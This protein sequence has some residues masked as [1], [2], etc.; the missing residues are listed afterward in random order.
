MEWLV[1]SAELTLPIFDAL[2]ADASEAWQSDIKRLQAHI[3]EEAASLLPVAHA[4]KCESRPMTHLDADAPFV[5]PPGTP[6]HLVA[7]LQHL[8]G[9]GP[10]SVLEKAAKLITPSKPTGMWSSLDLEADPIRSTFA[11][12][13][14]DL[15][16]VFEPITREMSELLGDLLSR[17]P[18]GLEWVRV[19]GRLMHPSADTHLVQSLL[20]IFAGLLEMHIAEMTPFGELEHVTD[21][22]LHMM[23]AVAYTWGIGGGVSP[24]YRE[25][26]HSFASDLLKDCGLPVRG[27]IYDA[28]FTWDP[29]FGPA[30]DTIS[31]TSIAKQIAPSKVVGTGTRPSLGGSMSSGNIFVPTVDTERVSNLIYLAVQGHLPLMLVGP[32]GAGKSLIIR[33]T[34]GRLVT[35]GTVQRSGRRGGAG[36]GAGAGVRPG[37]GAGAGNAQP[38][39]GEG[40]KAPGAPVTDNGPKDVGTVDFSDMNSGTSVHVR[41]AKSF[42]SCSL[43]CSSQT[44][45]ATVDKSVM[46]LLKRKP[47]KHRGVFGAP[48]GSRIVLFVDD[49]NM[50]M[51][52][53]FGTQPPQEL[54]RLLLDRGTVISRALEWKRI[55]DLVVVAAIQKGTGGGVNPR[56]QRHFLSATVPLPDMTSLEFIYTYVYGAFLTREMGV[57]FKDANCVMVVR[58]TLEL[59][60]DIRAQ[61]L[62]TPSRSHYIYSTRDLTRMFQGMMM[63]DPATINRK[64]LTMLWVHEC[65]RVLADRLVSDAERAIFHDSLYSKLRQRFA[66][67]ESRETF[68][69]MGPVLFTAFTKDELLTM[70]GD[71]SAGEGES[72]WEDP[73]SRSG[74]PVETGTRKE[75]DVSGLGDRSYR[76]MED[77]IESLGWTFRRIVEHHN[78]MHPASQLQMVF[79]RAT[80]EHVTRIMRTLLSPNGHML[81]LGL[82]GTGKQTLARFAAFAAGFEV[83]KCDVTRSFSLNEFKEYV[84]KVYRL[85]GLN[86]K[87]TVFLLPDSKVLTTN[88]FVEMIQNLLT[89]RDILALFSPEDLEAIQIE[90]RSWASEN[91]YDMNRTSIFQ[92]FSD[93][94]SRNLRVVVTRSPVGNL[95][96]THIRRFPSLIHCCTVDWFTAWSEDALQLVAR[97]YLGSL[98]LTDPNF[99]T[100]QIPTL[101]LVGQLEEL[102]EQ[103]AVTKTEANGGRGSNKGDS[104][105]KATTAS[106]TVRETANGSAAASV[107]AGDSS[108]PTIPVTGK[109]PLLLGKSARMKAREEIA[110]KAAEKDRKAE[111]TVIPASSSSKQK[112]DEL[113]AT[114]PVDL[115]A[116]AKGISGGIQHALQLDMDTLVNQG[117]A[118]LGLSTSRESQTC[119]SLVRTLVYVHQTM[120]RSTASVY[121]QTKRNVYVTPKAFLDLIYTFL[122]VLEDRRK[123]MKSRTERLQGGLDLLRDTER[124]V[125]D[126]R[127]E[128]TE[129]MPQLQA[130]LQESSELVKVVESEKEEGLAIQREVEREEGRVRDLQREATQLRDE[131]QAELDETMPALEAANEALLALNNNDITEIKSFVSPPDLV[132]LTMEA[133]SLL[134]EVPTSNWNSA[135]LLMSDG[136]AFIRRLVE[137]EKDYVSDRT[138]K[139]LRKYTSHPQFTPKEV[140]RHS[141]AAMSMCLWVRAVEHYADILRVVKPKREHL[142]AMTSNLREVER[143]LAEKQV[144]LAEATAQLALRQERLDETL[145]DSDHLQRH[146]ERTELRLSR[147]QILTASLGEEGSRWAAEMATSRANMQHVLGDAVLTAGFL[148]YLGILNHKYREEALADWRAELSRN[149]LTISKDWSLADQLTTPVVRRAW[150][151]DL[152]PFGQDAL[153][154]AIIIQSSTRWPLIIDPQGQAGRWIRKSEMAFGLHTMQMSDPQGFSALRKYL[155]RGIPV[156]MEGCSSSEVALDPKFDALLSQRVHRSPSRLSVRLGDVDVQLHPHARIY[157]T[158]PVADPNFA[159]EVGIRMAIV[160][161]SVSMQGLQEQLLGLVVRN[162]DSELE[163][164][165][166]H[167]V[168]SIAADAQQLRELEDRVLNLLQSAREGPAVITDPSQVLLQ[169]TKTPRASPSPGSRPSK[170]P[171]SRPSDLGSILDREDL[172]STLGDSKV[173][174]KTLEKR[175]VEAEETEASIDR[176]RNHYRPVATRGA[177]LYFAVFDLRWIDPMY[178]YSLDYMEQLVVEA[179][180]TRDPSRD[181]STDLTHPLEHLTHLVCRKVSSG[182]FSR[183]QSL[184]LMLVSTTVMRQAGIIPPVVWDIFCQGNAYGEGEVG[185]PGHPFQRSATLPLS[186]TSAPPEVT[187]T[188]GGSVSGSDSTSNSIRSSS[189]TP[190]PH[191]AAEP[192]VT[193]DLPAETWAVLLR[194]ERAIP[195]LAGLSDSLRKD[196]AS[197]IAWW[198]TED[199]LESDTLLPPTLPYGL[200]LRRPITPVAEAAAERAS[201]ASLTQ[202]GGSLMNSPTIQMKTVPEADSTFLLLCILRLV[203]PAALPA[204]QRHY[205]TN[206]L[207]ANVFDTDEATM[208][209]VLLDSKAN[210]PIVLL[211]AKGAD[212]T[213]TLLRIA[214]IDGRK[215]TS[216]LR[217]L[218]MGQGQG[219]IAETVIAEA[220]RSGEWVLLAN[221]HVAQSWMPRLEREVER[222][223]RSEVLPTNQV[224][225]KWVGQK[226]TRRALR[227]K[228][229]TVGLDANIAKTLSKHAEIASNRSKELLKSDPDDR[230]ALHP[231]FRLWLT[232][233][234][235]PDFAGVVL[236]ASLKLT[237]EPPLQTRDIAV[238]AF[239]Q[240]DASFIDEAF[241]TRDLSREL[242]VSHSN[243]SLGSVASASASDSKSNKEH[244]NNENMIRICWRRLVYTTVTLHALLTQRSRFGSL[245]WNHPAVF[246]G[247]DLDVSLTT[248]HGFLSDALSKLNN[249]ELMS[250]TGAGTDS[251]SA[252]VQGLGLAGLMSSVQRPKEAEAGASD[253]SESL[254]SVT[255]KSTTLRDLALPWLGMQYLVG[256]INYGGRITDEQDR[257]ILKELVTTLI[258]PEALLPNFSAANGTSHA[259]D[260]RA[261]PGSPTLKDMIRFGQRRLPTILA[262]ETLCLSSNADLWL[263]QA[264][265]R[266]TIEAL[267]LVHAMGSTNLYPQESSSSTSPSTRMTS[268]TAAT[269]SPSATSATARVSSALVLDQAEMTRNDDARVLALVSQILRAIPA[270]LDI[271]AAKRQSELVSSLPMD[272]KD[273]ALEG[274]SLLDKRVWSKAV[275]KFRSS[276]F[277]Q[278]R[279]VREAMNSVRTITSVTGRMV[280][281]PGP[282]EN[283]TESMS[284]AATTTVTP[285]TLPTASEKAINSTSKALGVALLQEVTQ[286]NRLLRTLRTSLEH[287]EQATKGLAMNRTENEDTMEAL[288]KFKVPVAWLRASFPSQKPLGSWLTNLKQRVAFV[289][290]WCSTGAPHSF[291][292]SA[293]MMPQGLLNAVVQ[294]YARTVHVSIDQLRLELTP[295]TCAWDHHY[296][297]RAFRDIQTP[298]VPGKPENLVPGAP[299]WED[300]DPVVRQARANQG[301]IF[302]HGVYLEGA[303]WRT[304]TG[305]LE[306]TP[307]GSL[308]AEL[309]VLVARVV[310]IAE[311]VRTSETR[312]ATPETL[313]ERTR[314]VAVDL[315]DTSQGAGAGASPETKKRVTTKARSGSVFGEV[316]PKS[317][318]KG[319]GETLRCQLYEM[320]GRVDGQKDSQHPIAEISVPVTVGETR[321]WILRGV[322]AVCSVEAIP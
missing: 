268:T 38:G 310:R 51:Q 180:T 27:S 208:E 49:L 264:E 133:V 8:Q 4:T 295:S 241:P 107:A 161:F 252:L 307:P 3:L 30:L 265:A 70:G 109:K 160:D 157:L 93:R 78:S 127:Q 318:G 286:F 211:T 21:G 14:I 172:I 106:A 57:A 217:V 196:A 182:L 276:K 184:I 74:S 254:L 66:Y 6:S 102:L 222:L 64:N 50:P 223:S 89:G 145:R 257:I 266:S 81:L 209:H 108:H 16:T 113:P 105:A 194:L 136:P 163:D 2:E 277:T 259:R 45:A 115:L 10:K 228:K 256:E 63:I 5:I 233:T 282:G 185:G 234:S 261:P 320:R 134:L 71:R 85:S 215:T 1:R 199:P 162:I 147:A 188:V 128:L 84:K 181:I 219:A 117:S 242:M 20:G 224:L 143:E 292:I 174:A 48:K 150:S 279:R 95:L 204:A 216:G 155:E 67:R 304:S 96:R 289:R 168:L 152:L 240:L 306:D 200:R 52:D 230:D 119:R 82:A 62:P 17:I 213:A 243:N 142:Q 272:D 61:L 303:A 273:A 79:F 183:H 146:V 244:G 112:A 11:G 260:F 104:S 68:D 206:C 226:D 313:E 229:S 47:G 245:G 201:L 69:A 322:A 221:C 171:T 65:S 39:F 250:A 167:L 203:R 158:C 218:S 137:F 166:D 237:I 58:S 177:V 25:A 191:P 83:F 297:E 148:T 316:K 299:R 271:E 103:Q 197:W 131:A 249:E 283:P 110:E 220:S 262:A 178:M 281:P 212:P 139:L 156:L 9:S 125:S 154:N 26:F 248:L 18:A 321:Q 33:E 35:E 239:Q 116:R 149:G 111:K 235:T 159:P 195:G 270:P 305:M 311:R 287:I 15:K 205:I 90:I 246:S 29:F 232:T 236:Q 22:A 121:L 77:D 251:T 37:V 258:R 75:K 198:S 87:R 124:R 91:G 53:A 312:A 130:K 99:D 293:L 317:R 31:S 169:A 192:Q 94:V 151:L 44:T 210:K 126:M 189:S 144:V 253:H 173:T 227:T 32:S 280:T 114:T 98:D 179:I 40:D 319:E 274:D 76:F 186:S 28:Q 141:Q 24:E 88:P 255:S 298:H 92:A 291:W 80:I 140:A 315:V 153:H 129:V 118:L 122:H 214:S 176:L 123:Q 301:A 225:R 231:D 193:M 263:Q 34:L 73:K 97:L 46:N 309:P 275:G 170:S 59:W 12:L 284:T 36:A 288:S 23:F 187:V 13:K 300:M 19:P 101:K 41:T 164:K 86:G 238:R 55:E 285:E 202:T 56:L 278:L 190:E 138:L 314:P 207:G 290:Q 42:M 7:R 100:L 132:Q 43:L 135:R 247:T 296:P 175:V 165:K 72:V 294:S 60:H 54:L 302:I 308:H 120:V 269:L 267:Q